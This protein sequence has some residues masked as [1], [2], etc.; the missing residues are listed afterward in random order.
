[1]RGY[2]MNGDM[3]VTSQPLDDNE[4][5]R[6]IIA[7]RAFVTAMMVGQRTIALSRIEPVYQL[8]KPLPDYFYREGEQ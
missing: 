4:V 2:E 3:P 8:P 1:M 7:N 6:E 5:S